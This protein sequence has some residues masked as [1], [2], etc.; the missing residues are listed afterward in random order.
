MGISGAPAAVLAELEAP[1]YSGAGLS[2]S[3]VGWQVKIESGLAAVEGKGGGWAREGGMQRRRG[4]EEEERREEEEK[5]RGGGGS[6]SEGG[7]AAKAKSQVF[8][9]DDLPSQK[10]VKIWAQLPLQV[11]SIPA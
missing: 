4:G 7:V 6:R 9:V 2:K 3:L 11:M 1:V 10:G 8:L 5:S